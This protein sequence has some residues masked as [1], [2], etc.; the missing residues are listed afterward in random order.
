MLTVANV[1]A[2]A[3]YL[4]TTTDTADPFCAC[5]HLACFAINAAC[6]AVVGPVPMGWGQLL[7]AAGH[8]AVILFDV[9]HPH[10]FGAVQLG[11]A[12]AYHLAPGEKRTRDEVASLALTTIAFGVRG[13][14]G[15][16]ACH[17]VY[18]LALSFYVLLVS[19]TPRGR[20]HEAISKITNF[21]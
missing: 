8:A 15:G 16:Y 1:V 9:G 19:Q 20:C 17:E 5:S 7:H 18:D 4:V 13:G 21:H 6:A 3:A 11:V 10:A 2:C 14:C 12:L